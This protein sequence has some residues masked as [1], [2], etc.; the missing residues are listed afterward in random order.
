MTRTEP[1]NGG[2][3]AQP[4]PA[5]ARRGFAA[6]PG[7]LGPGPAVYPPDMAAARSKV[8]AACRANGLAFLEGATPDNITQ[9]L[10][11]GVRVIAGGRADTALVGRAHSRRAMPV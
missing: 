6:R 7:Y 10:D 3:A 4:R 5:G 9:R 11:E 1:P 2:A 8:F